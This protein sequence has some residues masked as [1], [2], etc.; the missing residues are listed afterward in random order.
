MYC[1]PK[2]LGLNTTLNQICCPL[3]N[4][5][6]HIYIYI[7]IINIHCFRAVVEIPCSEKS[8]KSETSNFGLRFYTF[9]WNATSKKRK[10]LRFLDFQ[11]KHILELWHADNIM[12]IITGLQSINQFILHNKI[13]TRLCGWTAA[14]GCQRSQTAHWTGCLVQYYMLISYSSQP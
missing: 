3:R 8:T 10:K 14:A 2:I 5:W 9:F 6:C 4:Y 1:R 11:K 7:Y 13:N 12:H